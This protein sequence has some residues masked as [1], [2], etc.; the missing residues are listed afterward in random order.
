MS[1]LEFND[2]HNDL[3]KIIINNNNNY[4]KKSNNKIQIM[5]I[6]NNDNDEIIKLN[7]INE[8]Y[9]T[10]IYKLKAQLS[11]VKEERK[12]T[13]NDYNIIRH[14]LTLLKNQEKTNKLNFQNIK[15]RFK[16]IINNRLESQKR[17]SKKLNKTLNF[18][19]SKNNIKK[20][21]KYKTSHTPNGPAR[22]S[23]T[24]NSFY[25]MGSS[26]NKFYSNFENK[27]YNDKII[28]M[29]YNEEENNKNKLKEKLI[30]KLKEDEEEKKRIE[31]EIAKIEQEELLLLNTFKKDKYEKN[32]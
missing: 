6:Q 30:E 16:N 18:N 23:R 19:N 5:P 22:F 32:L 27:N 8:E 4:N 24:Y 25:P 15:Y 7:A 10:E 9:D 14:R 12:K 2:N 31:E 20:I 11:F 29:D 13:E 1:D 28:S 3:Q 26:S 21:N 17:I